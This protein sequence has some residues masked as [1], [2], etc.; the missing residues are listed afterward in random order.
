MGILIFIHQAP[1]LLHLLKDILPQEQACESVEEDIAD[2]EGPEA[3]DQRWSENGIHVTID[4]EELEVAVFPFIVDGAGEGLGVLAETPYVI[5]QIGNLSGDDGFDAAQVQPGRDLIRRLKD[6]DAQGRHSLLCIIRRKQGNLFFIYGIEPVKDKT[7]L[8]NVMEDDMAAVD[9]KL[10]DLVLD[11]Q[12]DDAV[13]S[14][15]AFI[16]IV[17]QEGARVVVIVI[18]L[19]VRLL[20]VP[21]IEHH[22]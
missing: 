6:C 10:E 9:K 7:L 19:A 14:S 3:A 22:D 11:L 12:A 16:F 2:D 20:R 8:G 4:I 17:P 15:D 1:E 18:D 13:A 5:F 21:V